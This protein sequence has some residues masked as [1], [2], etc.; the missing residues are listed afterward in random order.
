MHSES[1]KYPTLG[2]LTITYGVILC[3]C[4]ALLLWARMEEQTPS[5]PATVG[6]WLTVLVFAAVPVLL[7]Y[8]GCLLRSSHADAR[9]RVAVVAI[10]AALLG[11]KAILA[12][13]WA[14]DEVQYFLAGWLLA[15]LAFGAL[16]G[17]VAIPSAVWALILVGMAARL[18]GGPAV[19][20]A[21]R[22]A[23]NASGRARVWGVVAVG[24][25][26]LV[27]GFALVW[28]SNTPR[29]VTVT[30]LLTAYSQDARLA[31]AE[32]KGRCVTVSGKI[33]QRRTV[34]SLAPWSGTVWIR[35]EAENKVVPGVVTIAVGE[36]IFDPRPA[37]ATYQDFSRLT[38]GQ[39]VTIRG[40]CVGMTEHGVTLE[41]PLI[42]E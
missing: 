36:L 7:I 13:S 23:A 14:L 29:T 27:A 28:I 26:I 30:E 41:R 10:T 42:V 33:A 6:A 37:G 17:L 20:P 24:L 1:D 8:T 15:G 4:W 2:I 5:W 21:A 16:V 39:D 12:C 38:E 35:L 18:T 34:S 32:Y 25:A 11:A 40:R 19:D 3:F 22:Q 9:R 31:D